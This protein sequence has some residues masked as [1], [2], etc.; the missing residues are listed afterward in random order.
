M[1]GP[2]NWWLACVPAISFRKASQNLSNRDSTLAILA[3]TDPLEAK[4]VWMSLGSQQGF[5]HQSLP[6]NEMVVPECESKVRDTARVPSMH[7]CKLNECRTAGLML[8]SSRIFFSN[9]R[10]GLCSGHFR[11]GKTFIRTLSRVTHALNSPCSP[12]KEVKN[13]AELKTFGA[14]L[15]PG[16]LQFLLPGN[17][18]GVTSRN[19]PRSKWKTQESPRVRSSRARAA[20]TSL[21]ARSLSDADFTPS[22]AS[23]KKPTEI[24]R[25]RPRTAPVLP[26]RALL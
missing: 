15:V 24:R 8:A 7:K 17:R 3:Y 2:W 9:S 21:L 25:S 19:W 13:C 11:L 18:N 22:K 14:L 6:F 23:S 20:V 10:L 16:S 1:L 12:A 26:C 5:F 4:A